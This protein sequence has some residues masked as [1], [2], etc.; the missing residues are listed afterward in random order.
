MKDEINLPRMEKCMPAHIRK[1]APPE[2]PVKAVIPLVEVTTEENI[3]TLSS[4]FVHVQSTNRT[5]YIDNQHR[6]IILWAGPVYVDNYDYET[7]P[8]GFRNQSV[9][10]FS[11]GRLIQY[12]N[13][14]EYEVFGTGGG[15]ETVA[16]ISDQDWNALW[17]N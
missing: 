7:N 10:D 17:N 9:Y 5:Y 13:T 1:W 6:F 11:N 3:K 16:S 8:R 15:G 4:C 12:N 2:C 14:G